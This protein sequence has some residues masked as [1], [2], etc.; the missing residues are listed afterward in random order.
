MS[1]CIYFYSPYYGQ[2]STRPE[3]K[4]FIT[5]HT[6]TR[7]CSRLLGTQ[8]RVHRSVQW[9][10]V[11][12]VWHQH[13]AGSRWAI[14]PRPRAE[15]AGEETNLPEP[16]TI[17]STKKRSYRGLVWLAQLVSDTTLA[18]T[19]LVK[20]SVS[21]SDCARIADSSPAWGASELRICFSSVS[22][23]C[24]FTQQKL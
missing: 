2:K 16:E 7:L 19:S 22:A 13:I 23:K 5:F 4:L 17:P 21:E 1:T 9:V 15:R 8:A 10:G 18:S 24:L 14:G 12:V 20:S 11:D 3:F 6:K